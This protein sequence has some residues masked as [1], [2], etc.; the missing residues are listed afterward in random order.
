MKEKEVDVNVL[1]EQLAKFKDAYEKTETELSYSKRTNLH[2]CNNIY[3]L[4]IFFFFYYI[5]NS[6]AKA[7]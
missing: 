6:R 5:E 4:M 7:K 3:E 1:K 2:M